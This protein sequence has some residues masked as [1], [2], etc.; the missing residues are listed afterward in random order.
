MNR[1]NKRLAAFA[2]LLL[3]PAALTGCWDIKA[4]QDVNY[5][6]GIGIDYVDRKYVVYV[7]Q[8]D[9]S[10]VAKQQGMQKNQSPAKV[11]IGQASGRSLSEAVMELYQT[12]QQT[13]FWGHL[14][15]VVVSERFLKSKKI[16]E[17]F[18]ALTRSPE[19]RMTPWIFGTKEDIPEVFSTL[20]FFYLSPVNTILYAPE[21]S[22]RQKSVIAPIRMFRF[23]RELRDPGCTVKIPSIGI[24]KDTWEVN[25]KIDPKLEMNGYFLLHKETYKQWYSLEQIEGFKWM[26]PD[27]RLSR[28][29]LQQEGAPLATL[30]IMRPKTKI[31][32]SGG[33]GEPKVTFQLNLRAEMLELWQ[34]VSELEIEN[35][36]KRKVRDELMVAFRNSM[37][38]GADLFG[39]EHE[40][41]RKHYELWKRLTRDGQ[42]AF[43]P[44]RIPDIDVNVRLSDTGMYR[45][46]RKL[47]INE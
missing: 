9:F 45:L 39:I 36:A 12:A 41:Y 24:S 46:D 44:A 20:A 7:Q 34:P 18:D 22:F 16:I 33:E 19:I 17:V 8:L 15:T 23:I 11:W 26:N 6:T 32:I 37:N 47:E 43:V 5:F 14:N 1:W 42:T 10:S 29:L 21:S 31:R 28:L 30:R 27:T 4:I 13:I 3:V 38:N 2:A 40:L 35:A 25:K